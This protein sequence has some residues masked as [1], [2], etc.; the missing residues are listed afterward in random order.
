MFKANMI[1]EILIIMF[2]Y[3]LL[4]VSQFRLIYPG[5]FSLH[6][7]MAFRKTLLFA[8][9][10]SLTACT[11]RNLNQIN[12]MP[13]PDIYDEGVID[14]FTDTHPTELIPYRGILYATDRKPAPK[15]NE[16]HFY[17]NQRGHLLRLGVGKIKLGDGNFTWEEA[18][19]ISLLKNRT[20]KYPLKISDVTE[21]GILDRS[22]TVF[23]QTYNVEAHLRQAGKRFA[24]LINAKLA[25][26]KT[27]DVYI[28]VNGF[29]VVFENPLLVATELWHFLGYDG[30]FIAY[31]WP[32]TPSLWAY[33]SDLETAADSARNFRIFLKYLSEETNAERIHIIGYSAGTRVVITALAQ[34]ALQRMDQ[35]KAAVQ[36]E[37]RIGHVILVGSD[38]DGTIFAGFLVDGLLKVPANL[39]V[40]LSETD[41]AL[42]F[43]GWLF[44]RKRLGQ[45][46]KINTFTPA[47]K[48]YLRSTKDLRFID[49]TH[50]EGAATGNGHAYF[51]KS[52]WVSSDILL[53]LLYD[54]NPEERGLMPTEGL[55]IWTFPP[56]YI[57][58]LKAAL[59]K[60]NPDF[61]K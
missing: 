11:S 42:G 52:P 36:K 30:V 38:Y 13:A 58:R 4:M 26:S 28:Y 57:D 19:R 6:H 7:N 14:P 55:P 33:L 61:V 47:I 35:E 48:N 54:L 32:S 23:D 44:D 41:K 10:L 49:V 37:L 2:W 17:L 21:I 27:K 12:L 39:A 24:G 1:M 34:L 29:K 31:A 43:A 3:R 25:L 46:L 20:D 59:L 51:R 60:A 53:T 5:L 45:M 8:A 15:E 40:Y 18:R 16:K 56:D 22:L 9:I 50:A